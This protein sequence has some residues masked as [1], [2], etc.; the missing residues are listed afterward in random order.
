LAL[1]EDIQDLAPDIAR[2]PDD[3]DPVTHLAS[4][5]AGGRLS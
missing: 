3:R 4:P 5:K 1:G 2:R